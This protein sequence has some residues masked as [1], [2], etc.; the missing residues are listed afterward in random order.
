MLKIINKLQ[1]DRKSEK[2]LGKS[3]KSFPIT[4][5]RSQFSIS[6]SQNAPNRPI[7][8]INY[9]LQSPEPPKAS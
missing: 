8:S 1:I 9:S 3:K 2:F 4:N 5:Y 6:L 7:N